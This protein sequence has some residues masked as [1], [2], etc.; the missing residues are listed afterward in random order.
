M[1]H[2]IK[3][4]II[5]RFTTTHS[6]P[7]QPKRLYY[8]KQNNLGGRDPRLLLAKETTEVLG[9][10]RNPVLSL[11]L[12]EPKD[13][14]WLQGNSTEGPCIALLPQLPS[15]RGKERVKTFSLVLPKL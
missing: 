7:C 8:T 11:K 2:Y 5:L 15:D 12:D 9:S 1:H 6:K 14:G 4:K 3:K 10:S 13:H